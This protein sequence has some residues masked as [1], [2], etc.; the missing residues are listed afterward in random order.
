MEMLHVI[1]NIMKFWVHYN[2]LTQNCLD[3]QL[4]M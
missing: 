2:G 1:F 3:V 4:S